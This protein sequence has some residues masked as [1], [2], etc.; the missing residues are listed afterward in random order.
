VHRCCNGGLRLSEAGYSGDILRRRTARHRIRPQCPPAALATP[1]Q[2]ITSRHSAFLQWLR[3][4]IPTLVSNAAAI[5]SL[6]TNRCSVSMSLRT[7]ITYISLPVSP[8]I[9]V[10][11]HERKTHDSVA[12]PQHHKVFKIAKGFWYQILLDLSYM[13]PTLT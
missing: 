13:Q 3:P 12:C 7:F 8:K 9:R 6:W 11:Q 10:S 5:F 1:S 4:E 2:G